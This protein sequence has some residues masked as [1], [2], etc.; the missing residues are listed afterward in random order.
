MLPFD[1]PQ[2]GTS[3]IGVLLPHCESRMSPFVMGIGS[4]LSEECLFETGSQ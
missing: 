1:L 2:R 4:N 3:L